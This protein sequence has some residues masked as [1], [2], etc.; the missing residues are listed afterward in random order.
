[1]MT[2]VDV[3]YNTKC[4]IQG[5]FVLGVWYGSY[6]GVFPDP[7]DEETKQSSKILFAL[8]LFYVVYVANAFL[9]KKYGCEHGDLFK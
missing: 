9:D 8:L 6:K 7:T 4:V 2:S 5:F 1:M 3:Q